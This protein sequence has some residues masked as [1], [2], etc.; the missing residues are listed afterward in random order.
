MI[1]TNKDSEKS[2]ELVVLVKDNQGNPTGKKKS[3]T[4]DA[5]SDLDKFWWRYNGHN[6]LDKKKRK[7]GNAAKSEQDIKVGIKEAENYTKKVRDK[8]GLED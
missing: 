1:G 4:S 7:Q 2:F 5:G 3:I 8:R 6:K